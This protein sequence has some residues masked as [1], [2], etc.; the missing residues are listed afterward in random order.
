MGSGEA[1]EES[2]LKK[3][4]TTLYIV[5]VTISYVIELEG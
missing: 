3:Y 4:I 5:E 1:L 2:P